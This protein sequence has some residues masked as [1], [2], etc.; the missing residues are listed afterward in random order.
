ML[1]I[2]SS[3][4]AKLY[5]KQLPNAHDKMA[6]DGRWIVCQYSPILTSCFDILTSDFVIDHTLAL[7]CESVRETGNFLSMSTN[8]FVGGD[9]SDLAYYETV[10]DINCE[11]TSLFRV[12]LLT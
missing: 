2:H 10:V 6:T 8:V 4:K 11:N 9:I 7:S 12:S 1:L 3:Q 5:L